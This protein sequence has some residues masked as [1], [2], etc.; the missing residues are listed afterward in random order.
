MAV[1]ELMRYCGQAVKMTYTPEASGTQH[2][3]L[4][5]ALRRYFGYSQSIHSVNRAYYTID[6]W[7]ELI[8]SELD[9]QRPVIFAGQSSSGGHEFVI[10]GYDGSDMF[11]VNWGWAGK[12]D[13]YFAI[14]VLNPNDNTSMG[15]ASSTD[16]GFAT[17]QEIILGM[18]KS[19]GQEAEVPEI[20]KQL[21]IYNELIAVD[22]IMA[23]RRHT[24]ISTWRKHP[25][26]WA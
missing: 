6:G 9:H 10:D 8:W 18:E 22:T 7:K 26:I 2:E 17:N 15:S 11:H 1:A 25:I 12:N 19:T 21:I 5:N 20:V 13:G 3:F 16:L 24:P 14:N 23:I 4:V